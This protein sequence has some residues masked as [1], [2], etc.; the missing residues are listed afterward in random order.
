MAS[1]GIAL[2]ILEFTIYTS[3]CR[4]LY[5]H[6]KSMRPILSEDVVK[7]RLRSNVVDLTGHMVTFIIEIIMLVVAAKGSIVGLPPDLKFLSRCLFICSYGVLGALHIGLSSQLREDLIA[8]LVTFPKRVFQDRVNILIMIEMLVM[9]IAVIV[10]IN[11][12]PILY[13]VHKLLF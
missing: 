1:S 2:V 13:A 8:S 12:Q 3:I 11:I 6:N 5:K 10:V 4:F 9:V 7:K